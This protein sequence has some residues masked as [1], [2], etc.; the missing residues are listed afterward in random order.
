MAYQT[1]SIVYNFIKM[2]ILQKFFSIKTLD[3][4]EQNII[5]RMNFY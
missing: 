4:K 3:F 2:N 1:H 5:K